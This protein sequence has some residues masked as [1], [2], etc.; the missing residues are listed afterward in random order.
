[1][2]VGIKT[3]IAMAK[4]DLDVK[5]HPISNEEVLRKVGQSPE[6][7]Q[8]M[9]AMKESGMLDGIIEGMLTFHPMEDWKALAL[10]KTVVKDESADESVTMTKSELA[11]FVKEVEGRA[12][13]DC[14]NL[15]G[16]VSPLRVNGVLVQFLHS[17][18]EAYRAFTGAFDT[19]VAR[20]RQNDEYAED[21]RRR[22]RMLAADAQSMT[23]MANVPLD[24]GTRIHI[25][26]LAE[27]P[28]DRVVDWLKWC[29]RTQNV[30]LEEA[31][32]IWE[33]AAADRKD[34]KQ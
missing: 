14:R 28:L 19:P 12:R 32:V 23:N 29:S 3:A 18:T 27:P 10:A 6:R 31:A 34:I 13:V 15:I 21:A 30:T 33:R 26:P 9:D 4:L 11:T 2:T 5:A 25:E 1:M 22:M 17:F 16:R 8:F 20:R 24:F 7:I